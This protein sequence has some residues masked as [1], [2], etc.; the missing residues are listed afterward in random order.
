[1]KKIS[2]RGQIDTHGPRFFSIVIQSQLPRNKS[3]GEM[4]WP[5]KMTEMP[6]KMEGL[7]KQVQ[8]EIEEPLG[9]YRET[10][11]ITAFRLLVAQDHSGLESWCGWKKQSV[12]HCCVPRI[13][14]WVASVTPTHP[15]DRGIEM[16]K[17]IHIQLYQLHCVDGDIYPLPLSFR[18]RCAVWNLTTNA[19]QLLPRELLFG[20]QAWWNE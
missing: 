10:S 4:C 20:L 1:M 15:L 18:W 7:Q 3:I 2:T 19:Q 6:S 13:P 5:V 17:Y 11:A 9:L 16:R 14:L 8:W 12:K